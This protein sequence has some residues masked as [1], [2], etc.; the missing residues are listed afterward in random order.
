[1]QFVE[2]KQIGGNYHINWQVIQTVL[3]SSSGTNWIERW[4]W[5]TTSFQLFS[6][7]QTLTHVHS[8]QVFMHS[9]GCLCFFHLWRTRK[10]SASRK[11]SYSHSNYSPRQ[12][13]DY[14]WWFSFRA[15]QKME[16]WVHQLQSAFQATRRLWGR[17]LS[18]LRHYWL[19]EDGTVPRTHNSLFY[20]NYSA[21]LDNDP[22]C[23]VTTCF[24]EGQV[25]WGRGICESVDNY[26]Y[27][28]GY[29]CHVAACSENFC[30]R[31]MLHLNYSARIAILFD[32]VV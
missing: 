27:S 14:S 11:C 26:R 21:G 12:Q 8:Q 24:T 2:S 10:R 15:L 9:S 28:Q 1:M 23:S 22:F 25:C 16:Q 6:L 18:H 17:M 13:D 4:H 5:I 7:Q 31:T 29:N 20:Q 32:V 19:I 3:I 30:N